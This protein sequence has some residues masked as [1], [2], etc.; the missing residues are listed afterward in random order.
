MFISRRCNQTAVNC[1]RESK[2][3]IVPFAETPNPIDSTKA[4]N[5][6][7]MQDVS[8]PIIDERDQAA[9]KPHAKS[10]HRI[11]IE[12]ARPVGL[13]GDFVVRF[14]H[15]HPICRRVVNNNER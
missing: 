1:N 6:L 11:F 7:H 4:N 12:T 13:H 5:A 9:I 2:H 15:G 8:E 3:C 14:D 10:G